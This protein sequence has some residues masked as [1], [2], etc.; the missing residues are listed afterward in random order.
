MSKN[1]PRNSMKTNLKMKKSEFYQCL[2]DDFSHFHDS[3]STNGEMWLCFRMLMLAVC[4][5]RKTIYI[6]FSRGW[7]SNRC[8]HQLMDM[9]ESTFTYKG[10]FK[11]L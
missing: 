10:M 6:W 8:H 7:I 5:C 2:S 1:E 3:L 11:Y 9:P 4:L